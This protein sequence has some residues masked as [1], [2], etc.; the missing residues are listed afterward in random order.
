LDN[1][2]IDDEYKNRTTLRK[3]LLIYAEEDGNHR[4]MR[5]LNSKKT[6][7]ND[8]KKPHF[9]KPGCYVQSRT[10]LSGPKDTET[11]TNKRKEDKPNNK[12][13][14]KGFKTM[15]YNTKKNKYQ[16]NQKAQF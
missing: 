7:K 5:L 1:K 10:K 16:T 4:K 8:V 14:L 15:K 9:E 13:N 3:V 12:T 11:E 6:R 2:R